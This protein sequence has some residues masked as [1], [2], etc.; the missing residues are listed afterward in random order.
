MTTQGTYQIPTGSIVMFKKDR[1]A[2]KLVSQKDN[3]L[4]VQKCNVKADPQSAERWGHGQLR[5]R[6]EVVSYVLPRAAT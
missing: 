5:T 4:C 3:Q 1:S 2:Y 6:E